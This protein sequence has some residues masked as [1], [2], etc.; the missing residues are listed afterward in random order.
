MILKN[1]G[2]YIKNSIFNIKKDKCLKDPILNPFRYSEVIPQS[3]LIGGLYTNAQMPFASQCL[4]P[5]EGVSRSKVWPGRGCG[6]VEG[7]ARSKVW[8][9]RRCGQV[10]G[11]ASDQGRRSDKQVRQNCV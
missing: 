7:V 6:Q 8:L 1:T 3:K 9:G 4:D 2:I 10:E 5:V 11:V